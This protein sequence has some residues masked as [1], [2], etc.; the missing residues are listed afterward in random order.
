MITIPRRW[1]A[2]LAKVAPRE[3]VYQCCLRVLSDVQNELP[4]SRMSARLQAPALTFRSALE[5]WINKPIL[6]REQRP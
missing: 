3:L 5:S 6:N 4:M 1:W 2:L